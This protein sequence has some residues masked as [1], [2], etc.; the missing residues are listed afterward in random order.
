MVHL[1]TD[2]NFYTK[3]GM[4]PPICIHLQNR[5]FYYHPS[6][7]YTY[8]RTLFSTVQKIFLSISTWKKRNHYP[9]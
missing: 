6:H 9:F 1:Y 7:F 8:L 2:F 5:F 3:M 4:D